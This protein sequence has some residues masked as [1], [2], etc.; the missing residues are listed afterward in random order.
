MPRF[1]IGIII[2]WA[3]PLCPVFAQRT[4]VPVLCYHQ[5][6]DWQQGDSKN[7]R[8]Y[9]IPP[10]HF[11]EHMKALRDSG[12]R[13]I[14]PAE[15]LRYLEKGQPIPGKVVVLTFDDGTISQYN[16]A[17][18]EL[19]KYGFKAVFSIMTVTLDK[20]GYMS[21]EQVKQLSDRGHVIANHT[22]D[23]HNVTKYKAEDWS[24][25]LTRPGADLDR[26][27]G[28]PVHYF[29]YPFG[30]WDTTVIRKLKE[31]GYKG[32][33]QLGGKRDDKAREYTMRRMIATGYMNGGRLISAM[34]SSF[35]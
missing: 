28:K 25:Q 15:H 2:V 20:P 9:I 1:I 23:H 14:L 19:D 21:R 18:P 32:A 17:L 7:A 27:T 30:A 26:I 11:R 5:V 6:R 24:I 3:L 33:Y 31:H 29:V 4:E 22:W 16:H 8:A 13:T 35:R 10:A 12:Y 34:K